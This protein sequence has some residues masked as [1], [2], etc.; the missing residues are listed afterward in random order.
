MTQ[1]EAPAIESHVL[2]DDGTIPNSA[3]PLI[4]YRGAFDVGAGAP[5]ET[6]RARFAAN[7]WGNAWVSTIYP[8]HHYHSTA[9]EVLGIARGRVE[10]ALGGPKGIVATLHAGDAV[11]I[12]AGVGH[13]RLSPDRGLAVVGAY[14]RN[15]PDWDLLRATPASRVT[16]LANLPHVPLPET[17]PVL[18][19]DGPVGEAW[20]G[21]A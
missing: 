16:A 11:L 20:K 6:I 9:H 14:P 10:V 21:G 5:E 3:L 2:T 4:V 17:D 12:P 7:G 18:G 13:C 19:E 1:P 15:A 8:Y